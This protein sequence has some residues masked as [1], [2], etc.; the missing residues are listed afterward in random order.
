MEYVSLRSTKHIL[1]QIPPKKNPKKGGE[2]KIKC[3]GAGDLAR[4]LF[5]KVINTA[6]PPDTTREKLSRTPERGAYA[7][8]TFLRKGRRLLPCRAGGL[9]RPASRPAF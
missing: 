6:M 7:L 9:F 1:F 3:V 5:L 2:K 4:T 8:K